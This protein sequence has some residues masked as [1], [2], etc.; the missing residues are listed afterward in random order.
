[1]IEVCTALMLAV[2]SSPTAFKALLFK[3]NKNY[4]TRVSCGFFARLI[5]NRNSKR[6]NIVHLF[7]TVVFDQYKCDVT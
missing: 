5:L 2:I 3:K 4:K 6:T 1:M 7:F